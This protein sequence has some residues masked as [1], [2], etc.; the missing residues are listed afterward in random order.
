M[1][2][3]GLPVIFLD[4]DHLREIMGNAFG[5][6]REAR[7]QASLMYARLCKMLADQQMHVVCST[8]SLFHQTQE[9]NRQHISRYLEILV[10]VP[11]TELIKRDPK[12]IYLRARQGLLKNVVGMDLPAEF[13]KQPDIIIQNHAQASVQDAV[14]T[15]LQ[16]YEKEV[17][18]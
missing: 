16:F 18:A 4:G 9:W 11:L 15:I 2:A 6:D 5:H 10:D 8:I 1:R 14:A 17:V 3:Q 7:L 13:P 12:Q